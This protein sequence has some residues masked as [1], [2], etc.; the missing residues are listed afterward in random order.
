MP[1]APRP[2]DRLRAD[3]RML[4]AFLG[5]TL[6]E[7]EGEDLFATVERVRRLS[8]AAR[9]GD[10]A[11][12]EELAALLRSLPVEDALPVARAFA[13]FLALANIAEQH[14][15]IRRRREYREAGSAAQRGSPDQSFGAL[16]ADG[17][18]PA[19]LHR[20]VRELEIE[21]VLTAHPTEVNR[22]TILH[23]QNV[24]ADLLDRGDEDGLR[25]VVAE[26]WLTDEVHRRKP[27][28]VEE[29]RGGLMVF[30]QCL[31]DAVPRWLRSLDA[32]LAAATG[33]GLPLDVSPVRFGSWMGGDRDGNPNVTAETTRRVCALGRWI[34]ADLYWREV[35]ALRAELS[36]ERCS[37]ELRAAVGDVA[38]PYRELLRGVRDRL[39]ATREHFAALLAG[40]APD[41][42]RAIYLRPDELAAPLELCRRSLIATRAGRIA[43]GRLTDILRRLAAFG[44]V[45]ARL[46]IRQEAPRHA[47]ALD[48]VTRALGLGSYAEWDEAGRRNFLLAELASRRPLIPRE[49]DASE[50]VR[51]VLATF[52]EIARQPDLGAYVIS[53][54]STPSD[55]LAVLLLQKEAGVHPPL[56]VVPLFETDDDLAG[57]VDTMERLYDVA[58]W[59]EAFGDRQ[60]VMIGYSDSAKDAG[61]LAAA[62][63]LY[64][65]QERL[66]AGARARGIRLTLFHGR[67]GSVG[68]G[69]GP[70]HRA[71][72]SQPPGSTDGRLRV[73]EQ[74]EM[75]Q[76]KF[77]LPGIAQRTLDLYLTAVTEGKLRPPRGPEPAW[78]ALMSEMADAAKAGYRDLVRG[79]P[80]FVPYFR[81]VTPEQELG[82]LKIGSRPARRRKGGGVESLRAIPWIFAWT[83]TRLMLPSWLGVGD[84]LARGLQ[85]P[86]TLGAMRD[87][88]FL[89]ATLSLICMVLAKAEPPIAAMY[90]AALC[91]AELEG[92]GERLRARCRR[93]AALLEEV[94]GSLRDGNPV[95]ARTLD[96]RNPYVDPLNVLQAE[97]LRRFRAEPDPRLEEA[98]IVTIN[99]IAAGM[100]NTG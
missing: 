7:V 23:K 55:A 77:G 27:S 4:G 87:W 65:A 3:V 21:L 25:R 28:P 33:E 41:D 94:Q 93:T 30:E 46:D 13:Q 69:G 49:L 81:A 99:G 83:Q 19:D 54:A 15:R 48:A 82:R 92:L 37:D 40:E 50:D 51:E 53:M 75:I 86:D 16:L 90:D 18:A 84:G 60:E 17:V 61:R 38:E 29:A 68:R 62:W 42:D 20:T 11:A 36:L 45:L 66:V 74:G 98:L 10:A 39:D 76:A 14:H 12:A 32:S 24:I 2:D 91:P 57:A 97:L 47:E 63:S 78:R 26:I 79:E 9:K 58:P 73:T 44:L 8:R 1:P 70:M 5:D 96:L 35:D 56:R 71:I 31:W 95:L 6:K 22:R 80:D 52:A 88:P 85:D 34:A 59:R 67:G 89:D 100:R 43:E 64:Q 72:L